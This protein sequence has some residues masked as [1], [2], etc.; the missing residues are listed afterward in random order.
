MFKVCYDCLQQ[1]F[2]D[3]GWRDSFYF[4]ILNTCLV[5]G[6]ISERDAQNILPF[7]ATKKQAREC[8]TKCPDCL[9]Q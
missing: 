9:T 1:C 2:F 8:S 4:P 3:A 7:N 6:D 5:K